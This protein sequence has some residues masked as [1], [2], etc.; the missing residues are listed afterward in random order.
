[1]YTR[2]KGGCLP[3]PLEGLAPPPDSPELI[4]P[5]GGVAGTMGTLGGEGGR[6]TPEG[7]EA[8]ESH[9]CIHRV[10]APPL[11]VVLRT[12]FEGGPDG[13]AR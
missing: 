8:E 11:E 4:R 3:L 5:V 10:S 6:Q 13:Q 2:C 12:L 9:S 7:S 1:M